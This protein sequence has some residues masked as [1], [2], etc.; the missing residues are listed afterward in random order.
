[1]T[2]LE[3]YD[4]ENERKCSKMAYSMNTSGQI[5]SEVLGFRGGAEQVHIAK[6]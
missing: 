4:L 2:G 1:M 6:T 3:L 5:R